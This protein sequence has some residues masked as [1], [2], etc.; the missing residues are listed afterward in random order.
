MG[1]VFA[2]EVTFGPFRLSVQR[3]VLSTAEGKIPISGRAFDLLLLLIQRR[4]TLVSKADLMECA[5]PNSAVDESNLHVQMAAIRRLLTTHHLSV[6]TVAGRGYRLVG[7]SVPSAEASRDI[8]I[9]SSAVRPPHDQWNN[10][11]PEAPALIGRDEQLLAIRELFDQA[12]LVSLVGPG[13]VGKTELALAVA[14]LLLKNFADGCWVVDLESVTDPA[15]VPS[16]IAGSLRVEELGGRQIIDSL[17]VAVRQR[18]LLLV[19]DGCEHVINSVAELANRLLG[20]CP[21]LRILCTSQV[22]LGAAWEH[23]RRIA[24]FEVPDPSLVPTAIAALHYHAVRLF[25]DRVAAYEPRFVLTDS[26]VA[27]V[28]EI[29]R[30]LDGIP[31][32]IELAAARVPLLGL[33][34]VRLRIANRLDLLGSNPGVPPAHRHRTL[35]AAIAWSYGLLTSVE[36]RILR[37]LSVFAGGFSLAAAQQVAA[38]DGL[39][40][41][42]IVGGVSNLV[43]RS[44]LTAGTDLM[45][46]RHRMLEAM[47]DFSLEAFA[48]AAVPLRSATLSTTATGGSARMLAEGTTISNPPVPNSLRARNASFSHARRTSPMPFWAKVIVEPRAPASSTGAFP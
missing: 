28:L 1:P 39:A 32:A 15:L 45:L 23:V 31:L 47:R 25:V 41:W 37:R 17:I 36:S 3:R 20:N 6:L 43:R 34:P 2:D 35:R 46:P 10:L 16:V 9:S 26:T 4:G 22:P 27:S 48:T 11:P 29:C 12:R 24:P 21:G 13:G 38:G 42:D 33:E 40:E 19:L 18:Q 44:L 5:W 8:D 30:S 14:R 7:D